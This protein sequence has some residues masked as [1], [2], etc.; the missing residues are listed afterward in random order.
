MWD[1]VSKILT[2]TIMIVFCSILL[3]IILLGLLDYDTILYSF[4][5]IILA[6]G[7]AIYIFLIRLIYKK[8]IPKIENNKV[9]PY[10][11]IRIIYS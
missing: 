7:I 8:L 6:I 2:K 5:P 3:W 10:I 11:L 9:I 4:N 1:R